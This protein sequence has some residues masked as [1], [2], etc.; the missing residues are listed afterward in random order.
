[1]NRK[2]NSGPWNSDP[3]YLDP[4]FTMENLSSL[5]TA[6]EAAR[7]AFVINRFLKEMVEESKSKRTN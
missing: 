5:E 6:I 2:D 7:G 4:S 3:K 1:M